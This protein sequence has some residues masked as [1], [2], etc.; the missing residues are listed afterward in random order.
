MEWIPV[1]MNHL[2]VK[3]AI[4]SNPYL[5]PPPKKNTNKQNKNKNKQNTQVVAIEV[6]SPDRHS[7]RIWSPAIQI[8]LKGEGGGR[9]RGEKWC[10]NPRMLKNHTRIISYPTWDLHPDHDRDKSLRVYCWIS[11]WGCSQHTEVGRQ[12]GP[13]CQASRW[14]IITIP[15]PSLIVFPWLRNLKPRITDVWS[16]LS[17]TCRGG[18]LDQRTVAVRTRVANI[19]SFSSYFYAIWLPMIPT[20]NQDAT[21]ASMKHV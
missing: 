12:T 20:T 17:P 14:Y 4:K 6:S 1:Q 2:T 11:L 5:P 8:R 13:R 18:Q 10:F 15:V 3:N 21:T 9:G 19:Y 16:S 7:H